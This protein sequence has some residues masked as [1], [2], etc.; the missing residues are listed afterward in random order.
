M[1]GPPG[2]TT[3]RVAIDQPGTATTFPEV[4]WQEAESL[5]QRL[6]GYRNS[7]KRALKP[8][9]TT[10]QDLAAMDKILANFDEH[11]GPLN[12]LYD[13]ARAAHVELKEVFKPGGSVDHDAATKAVLKVMDGPQ[14][15]AAIV[16]TMFGP[17]F[18]KGQAGQMMDHLN[19]RV[20]KAH[21]EAQ[22]AIREMSVRRLFV[23]AN[24]EMLTPQ[25][26]VTNME[27]AFGDRELSTYQKILT[28]EQMA[29]LRRKYE[30]FKTLAE[31]RTPINPP[32]SGLLVN[33]LL[34]SVLR[35]GGMGALM[36]S[37]GG[38]ATSAAGFAAGT[39]AENVIPRVQAGRAVN[40]DPRMFQTATPPGKVPGILGTAGAV[41]DLS[42]PPGPADRIMDGLLMP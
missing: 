39:V 33:A 8:G 11:F 34:K 29:E 12:P 35:G 21:P 15:G 42:Q 20:F 13:K 36:G 10:S 23:D 27:R 4:T 22:D 18:S 2:S 38:P 41:T 16:D 3:R 9:E 1:A 28:G 17:Q 40:F 31:S 37:F 6:V 30:L 25:K 19:D 5:R 14:G 26:I 7:A 32:R 24:G